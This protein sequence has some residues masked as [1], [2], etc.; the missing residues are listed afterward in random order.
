MNYSFC[1]FSWIS[2]AE[3][4]I[5]Y[6]FNVFLLLY[7]VAG[8]M[9]IGAILFL[10]WSFPWRLLQVRFQVVL[11][12]QRGLPPLDRMEFYFLLPSQHCTVIYTLQIKESSFGKWIKWVFPMRVCREFV[13]NLL[14]S[15]SLEDLP[16]FAFQQDH[17][18]PKKKNVLDLMVIALMY[19]G[20]EV[21]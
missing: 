7:V 12:W 2:L 11:L 8:E 17:G 19:L 4:W 9:L 6:S 18:K 15:M 20:N 5:S 1:I 13:A 10:L 21:Q 14:V 3:Y 16:Q